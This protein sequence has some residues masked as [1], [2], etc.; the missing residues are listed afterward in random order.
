VLIL[1]FFERCLAK[2]LKNNLSGIYEE[3]LE[4]G[5][6]PRKWTDFMAKEFGLKTFR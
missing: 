2:T 5:C 4:V 3:V 1:S 6:T